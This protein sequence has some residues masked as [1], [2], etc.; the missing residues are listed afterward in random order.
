MPADF[1][2]QL[3]HLIDAFDNALKA[4]ENT[5]TEKVTETAFI[6][7]TT[8]NMHD[9]IDDLNTFIKNQYPNDHVLLASWNS[10]KHVEK[11]HHSPTEKPEPEPTSESKPEPEPAK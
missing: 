4:T 5:A 7:S 3:S 9:A 6:E 2:E 10:A 11:I 1:I 8:K